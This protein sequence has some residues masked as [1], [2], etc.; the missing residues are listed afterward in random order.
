MYSFVLLL[1]LYLVKQ[2]A[3]ELTFMRLPYVV[4][5]GLD[6]LTFANS[7]IVLDSLARQLMD[8]VVKI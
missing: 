8:C 1:S 7:D 4:V 3:T 2:Q 5:A 6:W